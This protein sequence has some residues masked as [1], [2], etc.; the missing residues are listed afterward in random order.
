MKTILFDERVKCW[1][2][3]TTMAIRDYLSLVDN[4]YSRRGGLDHQRDALKTTSGRRIRS[5]MVKD[6]TEGAIL[7]PVVLGVVVSLEDYNSIDANDSKRIEKSLLAEWRENISII[8]GM[9]RTTALMDAVKENPEI[10]DQDVRVECW[11]SDKTDSLIYRMLVLNTGQVPWN[12]KRQLLVVYSPLVEELKARVKFE[13]LLDINKSERRFKGGEFSAESLIESY[14]AFGLRKT[15]IDTQ[16]SLAEE[17]S[18]LDMAEAISTGKYSEYFPPVVQLMVDLDKA[19]SRL[20]EV[21]EEGSSNSSKFLIGRN[22]FDSQPAR[23]GLVVACALKI[24]GRLGNDRTKEESDA[25]LKLIRSGADNFINK[26][27]EFSKEELRDFLGLEILGER[28]HGQKRSA[29]GRYERSFF[30][31]AFKVLLEDNFEVA[32]LEV[33]WRA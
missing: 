9:Q 21:S 4:A 29:I 18:R 15:D 10:S 1:S 17:F 30:E 6:I 11:I 20:D 7:P 26:L 27:N 2:L 5:R 25:S 32:S 19:F 13:R 23:V 33:C 22:I 16:E 24:L 31:T 14:L 8:D 28:V 3:M 12:L